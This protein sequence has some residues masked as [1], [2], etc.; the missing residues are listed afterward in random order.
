MSQRVID[1]RSPTSMP[2]LRTGA[3]C[4]RACASAVLSGMSRPARAILSTLVCGW[5]GA[6]S[7]QGPVRPRNCTTSSFSLSTTPDGAYLASS[8][9]STCLIRSK[10]GRCASVAA[11]ASRL[12]IDGQVFSPGKKWSALRDALRE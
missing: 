6:G 3:F 4:L 12:G 9:R 5:P 10:A 2:R 7:S 11:G 8:S 1:P